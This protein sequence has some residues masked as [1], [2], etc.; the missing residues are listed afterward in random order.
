MLDKNTKIYIWYYKEQN[1][2]LE[3]HSVSFSNYTHFSIS[4]ILVSFCVFQGLK[5]YKPYV[6]GSKLLNLPEGVVLYIG[7]FTME[8][9]EYLIS[10]FLLYC[11]IAFQFNLFIQVSVSI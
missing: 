2:L 6:F 3:N 11:D 10:S 9:T 4:N 7:K 5:F 8:T 1:D